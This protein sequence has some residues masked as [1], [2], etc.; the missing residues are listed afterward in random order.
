MV[1]T[2]FLLMHNNMIMAASSGLGADILAA[3]SILLQILSLISYAFDGIAN[4]SSV[5]AGRARGLKD[6][7]MM[8]DVW[9]KNLQWGMGFVFY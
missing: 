4:T 1:R 7:N 3:N 6:N 9:K 8:K 2:F 5:F